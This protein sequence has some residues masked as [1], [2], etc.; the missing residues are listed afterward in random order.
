MHS[1]QQPTLILYTTSAC[2]LCEE[3]EQLLQE[4]GIAVL[5]VEIADDEQRLERYA[6]RIPVLRDAQRDT[7][8]DWPFAAQQVQQW[9]ANHH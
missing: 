4:L 2:H 1:T 7:E 9:L 3:A 6:R 5:T 8:L